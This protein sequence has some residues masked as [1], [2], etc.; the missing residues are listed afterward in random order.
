MTVVIH[1]PALKRIDRESDEARWI[2]AH[3]EHELGRCRLSPVRIANAVAEGKRKLAMHWP[4]ENAAA[5]AVEWA[6]S[7]AETPSFGAARE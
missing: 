1:M 5:A 4:K 6:L 7:T 3:V 2:R